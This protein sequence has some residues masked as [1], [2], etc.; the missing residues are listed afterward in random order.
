MKQINYI[1]LIV[2]QYNNEMFAIKSLCFPPAS[3]NN[4]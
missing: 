1:G 4:G 3:H 2:L